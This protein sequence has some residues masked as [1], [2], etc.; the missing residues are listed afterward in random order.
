MRN[1][2]TDREKLKHLGNHIRQMRNERSIS[3]EE[4]AE[5]AG[6]HRT[7]VGTIERGEKNVTILSIGKIAAAL[8]VTIS[9]LFQ[10]Y[11]DGQ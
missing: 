1:Y 5:L 3:Q 6:V 4:L 2:S 11:E 8:G 10:G 9:E 7:Y